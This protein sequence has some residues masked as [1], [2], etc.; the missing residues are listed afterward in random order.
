VENAQDVNPIDRL[1]VDDVVAVLSCQPLDENGP[2]R[3]V[4]ID[5]LSLL[6]I[7][8]DLKGRFFQKV[9][10]SLGLIPSLLV[11]C[12]IVGGGEVVSGERAIGYAVL[13]RAF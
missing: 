5:R 6:G 7:A 2:G 10:V 8:G 13:P 4:P 12:M 3:S 11:R 1:S 9:G